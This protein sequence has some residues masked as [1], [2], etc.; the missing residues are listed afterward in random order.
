MRGYQYRQS[1]RK[2][3][4]NHAYRVVKF[5]WGY[6]DEEAKKSAPYLADNLAVCNCYGCRNQ[7]RNPWASKKDRLTRQE[8]RIL[9]D[10]K[11]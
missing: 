7:R 3:A 1:H 8:L 10:T 2:R 5:A 4:L 6:S 9:S 11:L